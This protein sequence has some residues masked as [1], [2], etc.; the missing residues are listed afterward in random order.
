[1][2]STALAYLNL[3]SSDSVKARRLDAESLF[4]ETKVI[5]M[6]GRRIDMV[7]GRGARGRVRAVQIALTR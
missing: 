3:I 5:A 1:M 2:D 4:D 7:D 6:K